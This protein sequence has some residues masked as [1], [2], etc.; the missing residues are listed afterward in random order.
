MWSNKSDCRDRVT[1]GLE[2]IAPPGEGKV[3]NQKGSLF[4]INRVDSEILCPK[5]KS[6]LNLPEH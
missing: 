2:A 3:Y 5:T 6:V 4:A 1:Y